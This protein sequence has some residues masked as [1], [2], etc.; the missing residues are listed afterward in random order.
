MLLVATAVALHGKLVAVEVVRQ[1][2]PTPETREVQPLNEPVVIV[3]T[4]ALSTRVV[5]D[6]LLHDDSIPPATVGAVNPMAADS[7]VVW[8]LTGLQLAAE[9]AAGSTNAHTAIAPAKSNT[10]F[11]ENFFIS[12]TPL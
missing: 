8:L 9:D 3:R 5:N 12:N 11:L 10:P 6:E 1:L 4:C 7:S 2:A